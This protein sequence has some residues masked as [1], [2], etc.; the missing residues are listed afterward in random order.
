MGN[1]QSELIPIVQGEQVVQ[2]EPVVQRTKIHVFE[3]LNDSYYLKEEFKGC[4]DRHLVHQNH[5]YKMYLS[6][7]KFK[8]VWKGT[9]EDGYIELPAVNILSDLR[10]ENVDDIDLIES[11]VIGFN[12]GFDND[13]DTLNNI[14][15]CIF[16]QLQDFYKMERD[17]IPCFM[18]KYGLPTR[19]KTCKLKFKYKPYVEKKEISILVNVDQNLNDDRTG[20]QTPVYRVKEVK[21]EN[22]KLLSLYNPACFFIPERKIDNIV[23]KLNNRYHIKLKYDDDKKI[24]P[25][26]NGLNFNNH[27]NYML[28]FGRVNIVKMEFFTKGNSSNM[29]AYFVCPT[30]YM[31]KY[32]IGGYIYK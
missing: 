15:T 4:I 17:Y 3:D 10:F 9:T 7:N 6:K 12:K 31:H 18:F 19:Y 11:V 21:I 2:N 14:P 5:D 29:K 26:V 28:N 13:Y 23:L 32:G 16:K 20:F 27:A 8:R 25:L 30:I 1:K 24:V 22:D